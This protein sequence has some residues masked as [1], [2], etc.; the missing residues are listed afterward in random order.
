MNKFFI[1]IFLS[2]PIISMAAEDNDAAVKIALLK[3]SIPLYTIQNMN[4]MMGKAYPKFMDYM[5]KNNKI[6]EFN[7]LI[8]DE[9]AKNLAS[10]LTTGEIKE[11][12]ACVH[13]PSAEK[14]RASMDGSA[15]I[16]LMKNK[17][18]IELTKDAP[19]D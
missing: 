12:H 17:K 6:A 16:S 7:E 14:M 9:L 2:F 3:D 15:E 18:F 11:I 8:K 1:A 19:I 4:E 10:K 13:M 5:Q